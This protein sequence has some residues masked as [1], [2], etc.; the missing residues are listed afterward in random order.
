MSD[1]INRNPHP[2]F[3]KVEASRPD[4]DKSSQFRYTKTPDP[5]WKWGQGANQLL[6]D[7]DKA[8]SHIAIDP[9]Q[10]GRANANNYKLLISAIVPRPVAFISSR[11]ADGKSTNLAPFSYFNMMNHDPPMFVVGFA[12]SVEGAKDSL[13]NVLESKEC[14]INIISEPYIE[15]ANAASINAPYGASE[16]PVSGLTPAYDTETVKCAR[17][18]EAVF[19]LECKLD[20][21]KEWDSRAKPGTKSGTMAVFEATRFWAREDALNEDKNLIDPAV[22]FLQKHEE[23]KLG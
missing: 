18:K 1:S 17:V 11:S 8:K 20:M 2:D 22:S 14:V 6:S 5:S 23:D 21:V 19:S 9:H 16:W 7:A 13:R 3:K 15:A 12:S 4:F 10:E